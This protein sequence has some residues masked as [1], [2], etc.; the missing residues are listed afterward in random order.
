MQ[1]YNNL[2]KF[3]FKFLNIII[4]SIKS[5]FFFLGHL[6]FF[7]ILSLFSFKRF[8][9]YLGVF[10][11]KFGYFFMRNGN[12]L[13]IFINKNYTYLTIFSIIGVL[14]DLFFMSHS[15]LS[16]H[17]DPMLSVIELIFASSPFITV[18]NQGSGMDNIEIDKSLS[19]SEIKTENY[20]NIKTTS[21]DINN[22]SM[23]LYIKKNNSDNSDLNIYKY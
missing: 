16:V 13:M 4:S 11:N 12:N 20:K 1:A 22:I 6:T 9:Y 19:V 3:M 17:S 7:Q 15:F 5:A 21:E 8:L 14:G 2:Y 18:D 10:F 23:E